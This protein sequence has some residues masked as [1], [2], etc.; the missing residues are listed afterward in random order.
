MHCATATTTGGNDF[1]LVLLRMV[2][3]RVMQIVA[4]DQLVC[5]L[6]LAGK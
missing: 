4:L 1:L 5:M 2:L 6:A 3:G